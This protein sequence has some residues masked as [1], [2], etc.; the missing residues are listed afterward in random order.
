MLHIKRRG[1]N[2]HAKLKPNQKQCV[3][4]ERL[5]KEARVSHVNVVWVC[6]FDTVHQR[7]IQTY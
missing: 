5:I 2:S 4:K 6:N 1:F 7:H 3:K